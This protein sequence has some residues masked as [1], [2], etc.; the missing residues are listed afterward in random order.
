M[1]I[2]FREAEQLNGLIQTATMQYVLG[3][4]DD[5]GYWREYERWLQ[6]GGK[7]VIE[8]YAEAYR[9]K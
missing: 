4:I 5:A 7:Q 9:E 8:E 6:E 1:D 3:E 2:P